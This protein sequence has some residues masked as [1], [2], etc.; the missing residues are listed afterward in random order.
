MN[1]EIDQKDR[2]LVTGL[3]EARIS[4]LHAE[5]RRSM[6]HEFKDELKADLDRFEKLLTRLKSLGTQPSDSPT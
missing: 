6:Q 4:E 2:E 3:V 1:L 5:I